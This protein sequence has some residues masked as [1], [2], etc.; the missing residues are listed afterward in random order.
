MN[1]AQ[2]GIAILQLAAGAVWLLVGLLFL[3]AIWRIWRAPVFNR[4]PKS[5]EG[6]EF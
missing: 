4:L 1:F 2:T 3:P 5:A 6:R